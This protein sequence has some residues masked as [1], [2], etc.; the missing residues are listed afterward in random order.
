MNAKVIALDNQERWRLATIKRDR[1]DAGRD[2]GVLFYGDRDILANVQTIPWLHLL[3]RSILCE[4]DL[5]KHHSIQFLDFSQDLY[6]DREIRMQRA[7]GIVPYFLCVKCKRFTRNMY[8]HKFTKHGRPNDRN[9]VERNPHDFA[10]IILP[11]ARE[12]QASRIRY[13]NYKRTRDE[14]F[15]AEVIAASI[16]EL[17]EEQSPKRRRRNDEYDDFNNAQ[18]FDGNDFDQNQEF[19]CEVCGASFDHINERNIHLRVHYL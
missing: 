2:F 15:P 12:I 5:K 1:E 11:T 18:F 16:V 19:I 8:I 3:P 13:E 14:A 9:L 17:E 7:I 6:G 10:R 4:E